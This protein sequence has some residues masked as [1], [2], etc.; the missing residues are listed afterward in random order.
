VIASSVIAASIAPFLL[1]DQANASLNVQSSTEMVFGARLALQGSHTDLG[2]Q[3][4]KDINLDWVAFDFD[5]QKLWPNQNEPVDFTIMDTV[6]QSASSSGIRVLVSITNAP[7][8]ARN[9]KGPT[10]KQTAKL[11][12]SLVERYEPYN[13][14]AIEIFPAA[15]TNAGWG[16][17]PDPDAYMRV[18]KRCRKVLDNN[19]KEQFILVAGGLTALAP[20]H[21]PGD[22]EDTDFLAEM[23]NSGITALPIVS[24]RLPPSEN[25]TN[26]S[27]TEGSA[28]GLRR[29]E[30]LRMTMLQ[31][32][33]PFSKIWVTGFAWP[34][35]PNYSND[36]EANWLEDAYNLFGAQLYIEITFFDSLNPAEPSGM[37][38]ETNVSLISYKGE[39]NSAT[40]VLRK[41]IRDQIGYVIQ[42][43]KNAKEMLNVQHKMRPSE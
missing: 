35:R 17:Q 1:P 6:I 41:R 19:G 22:L 18:Y 40:F 36:F 20:G 21:A 25:L 27:S 39:L 3:T 8:W 42:L 16:G 9:Q 12:L 2:L 43:P 11:V 4:A 23:Y 26:T 24:I 15:N 28:Q 38:Y 7:Q 14:R 29:Y 33:K 5:W 32:N 31:N 37:P 34:S 10:P 30:A 13:L